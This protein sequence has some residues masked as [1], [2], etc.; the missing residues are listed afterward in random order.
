MSEVYFADLYEWL[1]DAYDSA[2]AL[3]QPQLAVQYAMQMRAM[4]VAG[5]VSEPKKETV[6]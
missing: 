1:Q 4:E 5:L 6:H 2:M 3:A